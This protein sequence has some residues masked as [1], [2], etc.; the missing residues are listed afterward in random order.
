MVGEIGKRL[1]NYQDSQVDIHLRHGR[2]NA[3]VKMRYMLLVVDS[4]H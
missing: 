2:V 3:S 1:V 4:I